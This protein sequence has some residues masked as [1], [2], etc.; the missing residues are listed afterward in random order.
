MS[1][2]DNLSKSIAKDGA[3]LRRRGRIAGWVLGGVAIIVLVVAASFVA[4]RRPGIITSMKMAVGAQPTMA[5]LRHQV[6]RHPK[7]VAARRDLGHALFVAHDYVPAVHQYKR[8]LSIDRNAAD[9]EMVADLVACYG[10]REQKAAAHVI[11]DYQLTS[12]A[13]KLAGLTSS[14][15]YDVRWGALSTLHRLGKASRGEYVRVYLA[16]LKSSDCRVKRRAVTELGNIGDQNVLTA[17][18]VAARKDKAEKPW[19][20]ISPCLGD[21]PTEA[22]KA[23]RMRT[24]AI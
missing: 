19:Y 13:P 2:S 15:K 9:P 23:I 16:D 4:A 7:D 18:E 22:E 24:S 8:A 5:E 11:V 1:S 20:W 17:I 3:G 12:A 14:P 10:K 21:R 6:E